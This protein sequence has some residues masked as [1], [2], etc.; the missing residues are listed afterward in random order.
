MKY[1]VLIAFICSVSQ[2]FS[3]EDKPNIIEK[4]DPWTHYR[5]E[6]GVNGGVNIT[7]VEG[8]NNPTGTIERSQGYLYGITLVYH[9]NRFFAFKTDFD[10]EKKG[11]TV[12]NYQFPYS[13]TGGMQFIQ[14]V[15]QN[16]SY[17]DIPAF[18]HVGFGRKLKLDLNFGP[19]VA[20]LTEAKAF[21]TNPT[22]GQ[23]II[24]TEDLFTN[25]SSTDYGLTFGGGFDLALGKRLSFGFDLLYEYGLKDIHPNGF[26]NTSLDFDFGINYLFGEKKKK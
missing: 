26:R 23:E 1:L 21:Y 22:S 2:V 24:V 17:F 12:D 25:Y 15:T 3:Q 18:L 6:I 11:W 4:E 10:L 7:G 16:L 5:W 20:F 14:D 9:F 13:S 19:Y 8:F